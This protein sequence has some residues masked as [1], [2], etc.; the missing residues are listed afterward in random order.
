LIERTREK[1]QVRRILLREITLGEARAEEREAYKK[2]MAFKRNHSR[3]ARDTFL[4]ELVDVIAKEGG[5]QHES[6][7]KQLKTREQIRC[8]HRRIRWVFES[9]QQGAI[10]FVEVLDSEGNMVERATK[11]EVERA[12]MEENERDFDRRMIRHS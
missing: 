4:E 5:V 10:T 9:Q 2:Y 12:C 7:V 3:E 11:D 6:V 1:G 8:T